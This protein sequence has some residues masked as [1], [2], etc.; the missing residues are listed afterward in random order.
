[1]T[2]IK[3]N[4]A[5]R[6]I[7]FEV[8]N[9]DAENRT[10]EV[11]ASTGAKVLRYRWFEDPVYEEIEITK[12]SI[13]FSR[14]GSG[15]APLLKDHYYE[16][17]SQIGVIENSWVEE[18]K[19]KAKIRFSKRDD[20]EP[21]YQDILDG[22]LRNVSIG[23]RVLDYKKYKNEGDK[24]ETVRA[25]KIL[26]L[27]LSFV[28]VPAD[29]DAGV[30]ALDDDYIPQII[31]ENRRLLMLTDNQTTTQTN[32]NPEPANQVRSNANSTSSEPVSSIKK[33]LS[34]NDCLEINRICSESFLD[35]TRAN[36]IIKSVTSLDEAKIRISEIV[37][38]D[39]KEKNTQMRH[40]PV[41]STGHDESEFTRSGIEEALK[42][43]ILSK[44]ESLNDNSKRF[45]NL[46][47]P[48]MARK[49]VRNGELYNNIE[50]FQRAITSTD[51]PL[52]LSNIAN[53]T[54]NDRYKTLDKTYE[55]IIRPREVND[56]NVQTELQTGSFRELDDLGELEEYTEVS[57][58]ESLET[59]KI[60]KH[61]NKFSFSEELF[62]NDRL[63]VLQR[64]F[65]MFADSTERKLS[66]LVYNNFTKNNLIDG[67][68]L[69]HKDRGN[70]AVDNADKIF[71]D[72]VITEALTFLTQQFD[73]DS[74]KIKVDKYKYILT[75]TPNLPIVKRVLTAVQATKA[76]DIN[77]YAGEFEI[78]V[79]DRL[80]ALGK[81]AAIFV[82]DPIQVD[83]IVLSHLKGFKDPKILRIDE[84]M[85][86]A[87]TFTCKMFGGSKA[88]GRKG[89]FLHNPK[90]VKA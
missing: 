57:F 28:T 81:N 58:G 51:L 88:I 35:F 29:P 11:I 79:E 49:L 59:Y 61:G 37:L 40:S 8:H 18:G 64:A 16:L 1:M 65:E 44:E 7:S 22:I 36:E 26:P 21:I 75:T 53:K 60:S 86:N 82:C 71:S 30:R 77:I 42:Y 72:P 63:D 31:I 19:L 10:I 43:R 87:V 89:F 33:E 85:K 39:F 38:K 73:V 2:I 70:I 12:D 55:K 23:Y 17:N 84:P 62:I 83:G 41:T 50:L 68:P 6:S 48:E 80:L 14:F 9:K 74:N 32:A 47:M 45:I 3:R 27:E 56:L 25:T 66:S 46:S 76:E 15:C 34:T 78:I 20:V 4:S 24:Y 69:F 13:D 5:I 90:L 67:K 54:L 52:I